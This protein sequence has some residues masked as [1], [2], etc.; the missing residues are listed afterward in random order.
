MNLVVLLGLSGCGG[1]NT[2]VEIVADPTGLIGIAITDGPVDTVSVVNVQFTGVTLKPQDDMQIDF[3]FDVPKDFDLLTL[4]SGVTAEL[5]AQTAV[6]V[7]QRVGM[8]VDHD[9][10]RH[11][12]GDWLIAVENRRV[13]NWGELRLLTDLG[14]AGQGIAAG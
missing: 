7:A 2:A 12:H 5:L 11:G 10:R 6:P 4:T 13:L 8:P 3:V 9:R 14:Q 1:G